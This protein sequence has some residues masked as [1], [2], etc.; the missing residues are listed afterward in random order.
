MIT[1]MSKWMSTVRRRRRRGALT[2]WRW[3]WSFYGNDH[4]S[5]MLQTSLQ[6]L[7]WVL[8]ECGIGLLGQCGLCICRAMSQPPFLPCPP[9]PTLIH[10]HPSS[11]PPL[12]LITLRMSIPPPPL[13]LMA[14]AGSFISFLCF[15]SLRTTSGGFEIS[16]LSPQ[17]NWSLFEDKIKPKL[18]EYFSKNKEKFSKLK[19]WFFIIFFLFEV[20][21]IIQWNYQ[22]KFSILFYNAKV[23]LELT[24]KKTFSSL[25]LYI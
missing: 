15:V 21:I 13:L 25:F 12:P 6:P 11:L 20:W 4:G 2:F 24:R 16:I 19:E 10:H 23:E 14:W 8:K 22:I 5:Q 17:N 1:I 7:M 3:L 18:L 9:V